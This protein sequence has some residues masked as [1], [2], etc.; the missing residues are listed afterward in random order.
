MRLFLPPSTITLDTPTTLTN[1]P[2]DHVTKVLRMRIGDTLTLCD[3]G[4]T[5]YT[6]VIGS[7]DKKS[8]TL[9]VSDP[10]PNPNEPTLK[11]TLVAGLPKGSKTDTIIQKT[12]ELGVT[13]IVFV[14]TKRSNVNQKDIDKPNKLERLHKIALAAAQQSQRGIVPSITISKFEHLVAQFETDP[15][16]DKLGVLFYEAEGDN[17]IR[18]VLTQSTTPTHVYLFTG[19]EGGFTPEE[20]TLA[21]Q[22]GIQTASLGPRIL[23]TE[24]AGVVGVGLVMYAFGEMG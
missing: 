15:T 4:A 1:E 24:T 17:A 12:V 3:G 7:I 19:P 5:D 22:A 11:L 23:R 8:A 18:T 14:E 13:D 21:K 9:T 20:V 2:F 10:R 6:A 16:P